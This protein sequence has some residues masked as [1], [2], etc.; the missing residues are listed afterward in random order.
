MDRALHSPV[1]T[2][3]AAAG[4]LHLL[5]ARSHLG[6]SAVLAAAFLAT[7]LLQI[8]VVATIRRWPDRTVELATFVNLAAIG[9]WV[10]SRTV[11]LPLGGLGVEPVGLADV[12]TVALEATAV[13]VPFL[14]TRLLTAA[15]GAAASLALIASLGAV[16]VAAPAS[17]HA[18]EAGHAHGDGPGTEADDAGVPSAA[19]PGPETTR[20]GS[21]DADGHRDGDGDGEVTDPAGAATM[22]ALMTGTAS[23]AIRTGDDHPPGEGSHAD[24]ADRDDHHH[25]REAADHDH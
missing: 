14:S 12:V 9:G 1:V 2:L 19:E 24:P 23:A 16:A 20:L 8:G 7:A 15:R 21:A 6:V 18:H 13:A 5:A 22:K 10:T 11:G 25:D 3:T 4:V 17:D